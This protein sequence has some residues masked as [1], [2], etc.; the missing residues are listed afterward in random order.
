VKTT[1]CST[2]E[3]SETSPRPD[4]PEALGTGLRLVSTEES[5]N[6]DSADR[7][8]AGDVDAFEDVFRHYFGSLCSL[9]NGYVKSRHVAEEVVQDLLL[10]VWRQRAGLEL[11]ESLGVYLFR[12]AR[13]RALNHERRIRREMAWARD[14]AHVDNPTRE[15]LPDAHDAFESRELAIAIETAVARLPERRRLAFQL[16]QQVGLSHAEAAAVMGIAP[17]TVAIHL[18][19]ARQELRRRLKT[20]LDP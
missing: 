17:K 9:V 10:T 13:N 2:P 18:G 16:T 15:L 5:T 19:L 8:R 4:A 1:P 7:I 12:A 11:R 6:R 3:S 14:A 20:F